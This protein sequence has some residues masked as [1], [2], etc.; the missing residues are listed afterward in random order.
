VFF[1]EVTEQQVNEVNRYF[2]PPGS[3]EG[4]I[5]VVHET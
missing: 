1:G 4:F 2:T 5:V 3:E